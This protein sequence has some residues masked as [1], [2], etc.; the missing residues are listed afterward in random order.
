MPGMDSDAMVSGGRPIHPRRVWTEPALCGDQG[1]SQY[2][3]KRRYVD[4]PGCIAEIELRIADP[5]RL[6]RVAPR[7]R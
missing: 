5:T 1:P 7:D 6:G 3:T 4:C 2:A